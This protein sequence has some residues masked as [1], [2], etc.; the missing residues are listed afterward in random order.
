[1][2]YGSY[3]LTPVAKDQ[4]EIVWV[5]FA[6]PAGLIP[7]LLVNALI[8]DIPFNSLVNLRKLVLDEKYQSLQIDFDDQGNPVRLIDRRDKQ[9]T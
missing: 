1:M 2:S 9:E 6:D 8:V 5:H 7:S 3:T 4:I